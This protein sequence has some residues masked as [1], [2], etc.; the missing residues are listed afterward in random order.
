[1]NRPPLRNVLEVTSWHTQCSDYT[2]R[3]V[4]DYRLKKTEYKEGMYRL[5][6]VGGFSYFRVAGGTIPIMSLEGRENGEW[7][8]WMIDDPFNYMA[9]REYCKRLKGRVL[10]SGLGLGI[11]AT[12]LAENPEVT[13][14][15]VAERS[16]EVIDL[17]R[18]YVP[19]QI[20]VI[21]A[22][23]WDVAKDTRKRFWR[24]PRWDGILLDIWRSTGLQEHE[25][26]RKRDAIP[27][28]ARL[29]KLHP[30]VQTVLF[31]FAEQS[32]ID[33]QFNQERK[34]PQFTTRSV[35]RD[36]QFA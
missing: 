33:I 24:E 3:T 1:M 20:K 25:E 27:A 7:R 18:R 4:G 34:A 22:D 23:F 35:Q 13:E 8:Q 15:V 17:V 10:T 14:I 5:Y 29:A 21:Q 2:E 16:A 31:G 6:R 26:V 32:D 36:R 30:G 9:V 11:A 28:R 12:A 19:E